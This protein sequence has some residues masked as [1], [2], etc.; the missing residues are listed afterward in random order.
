MCLPSFCRFAGNPKRRGV[1]ISRLACVVGTAIARLLDVHHPMHVYLDRTKF[2]DVLTEARDLAP[3]L[4]AAFC[5]FRSRTVGTVIACVFVQELVASS[6]MRK[7][8]RKSESGYNEILSTRPTGR[9]RT[10]VELSAKK[11]HE[12]LQKPESKL[13]KFLVA[14]SDGGC[15][16][17]ASTHARAGAGAV[18]HLENEGGSK[19]GMTADEFVSCAVVHL[20][21]E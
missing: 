11:V 12:W 2:A 7:R 13:R 16:F 6:E 21:D 17:S 5:V 15:F 14:A 19:P 8:S 4:K 10:Q 18:L 9:P 3:H 20:C 1:A